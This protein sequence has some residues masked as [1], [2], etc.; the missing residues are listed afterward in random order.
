MGKSDQRY[1]FVVDW[2]DP[3]ASLVRKY[4]LIYYT[5]DGTIEMYDLKNRRTFLK[6]NQG[7]GCSAQTHELSP[8]LRQQLKGRSTPTRPHPTDAC[9]VKIKRA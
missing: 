9:A 4:Q 3:A 7:I 2:F 8:H 5:A 1:C 6:W